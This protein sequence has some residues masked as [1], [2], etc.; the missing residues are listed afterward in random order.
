MVCCICA[1][2]SDSGK[3]VSSASEAGREGRDEEKVSRGADDKGS[4]NAGRDLQVLEMRLDKL[5]REYTRDNIELGKMQNEAIDKDPE[6]S[7]QASAYRKE[8]QAFVEKLNSWPGIKEKVALR[9]KLRKDALDLVQKTKEAVAEMREIEDENRKAAAKEEV[10]RLRG[11]FHIAHKD[12]GQLESE[13][14]RMKDAVRKSD[15]E[16]KSEHLKLQEKHH[17][18]YIG[19]VNEIPEIAEL[20]KVQH[21]REKRMNEMLAEIARLRMRMTGGAVRTAKGRNGKDANNG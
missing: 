18:I 7:K 15:P 1:G 21:E 2:C 16:I 19:K 12:L 6:L 17:L 9:D 5:K 13:I 20:R 10:D 14:K 8:R 11:Q 3:D 4:G